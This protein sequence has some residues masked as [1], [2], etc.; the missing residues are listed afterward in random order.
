MGARRGGKLNAKKPPAT[1]GE[2]PNGNE[3]RKTLRDTGRMNFEGRT[4]GKGE[5]KKIPSWR[6]CPYWEK[7]GVLAEKNPLRRSWTGQGRKKFVKRDPS[8]RI[9]ETREGKSFKKTEGPFVTLAKGR[10]CA[11]EKKGDWRAPGGKNMIVPGRI[12]SRTSRKKR[13]GR[14]NM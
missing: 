9:R 1:I 4:G 8:K 7:S 3:K 6:T 14:K 2:D 5:R 12:V 13:E 11:G 10:T